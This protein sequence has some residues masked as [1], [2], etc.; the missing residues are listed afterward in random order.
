ME[1]RTA[2]IGIGTAVSLLFFAGILSAAV[3]PICPNAQSNVCIFTGVN[4]EPIKAAPPGLALTANQFRCPVNA[5]V[6]G[7]FLGQY[8][9]LNGE[10][11]KRQ[12]VEIRL[13]EGTDVHA[14]AGGQVIISKTDLLGPGRFVT[15]R[16]A[17]NPNVETTYGYLQPGSGIKEEGTRV[18]AGDVIGKS[19]KS[20]T[21]EFP[22]LYFELR[23]G[24]LAQRDVETICKN[25]EAPRIVL[26]EPGPCRFVS[27]IADQ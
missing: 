15:I 8:T 3:A 12:G 14:A 13:P 26:T 11:R 23:R 9:N 22:S 16:H 1:K 20:E 2:R 19:G 5:P 24:G 4:L 17:S 21:N 18:N 10:T 6:T 27:P 25:K 7:P